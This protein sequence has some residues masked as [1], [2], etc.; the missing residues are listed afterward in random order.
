MAQSPV[1]KLLHL[2]KCW[3]GPGIQ[4]VPKT[5]H[6]SRHTAAARSVGTVKVRVI[7]LKAAQPV[8]TKCK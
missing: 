6:L 5:G 4:V 1:T 8:N 3:E 2:L 7:S